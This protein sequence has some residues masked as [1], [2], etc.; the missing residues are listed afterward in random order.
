MEAKLVGIAPQI[1]VPDVK[2]TVEY[3]INTLG[4]TLIDYFFEEPP[5]YGIVVREGYQIH[6]GKAD[7]SL[8]HYNETIRKGMPDFLI[9]VPGI[10]SFYL[11]VKAKGAVI[12]QDIVQRSYG[13]EFIIEDCDG[14]RV[15][16]C[17]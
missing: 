5:V 10:D 4:F 9:W 11:E 7:G 3:Y 17:D 1:V 2:K 8:I 12:F 16:V 6:F 15:H 13:R 14:H